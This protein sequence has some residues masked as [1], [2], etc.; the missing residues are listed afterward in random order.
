MTGE[1][2]D[3]LE[4][5]L[6]REQ[7][8]S[9]RDE[10]I[11]RIRLRRRL[12]AA[13]LAFFAAFFG[14]VF[15]VSGGGQNGGHSRPNVWLLVIV[16]PL[17]AFLAFEVFRS[18]KQLNRINTHLSNLEARALDDVTKYGWE[19][20][21]GGGSTWLKK[22]ALVV[23]AA[24]YIGSSYAGVK[25]LEFAPDLVNIPK[26]A[27]CVFYAFIGVVFIG[28]CVYFL[29]GGDNQ[30][31]GVLFNRFNQKHIKEEKWPNILARCEVKR[32]MNTLEEEVEVLE[33][34]DQKLYDRFQDLC[35]ESTEKSS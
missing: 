26:I 3:D 6:L 29:C 1:D 33:E 20:T 27:L 35:G 22:F 15:A 28:L 24:F 8:V 16:P 2:G 7:Y 21:T 5:E 17:I 14:Y 9:L 32:R 13:A 11:G 23:I 19:Y 10:A 31:N 18:E 30:S 12:I 25:L 4:N 34:H